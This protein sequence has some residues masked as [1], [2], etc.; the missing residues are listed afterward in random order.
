M[1]DCP[2]GPWVASFHCDEDI[3]L[4]DESKYITER[5]QIKIKDIDESLPNLNSFDWTVAAR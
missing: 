4:E 5:T 1:V 3:V 2:V